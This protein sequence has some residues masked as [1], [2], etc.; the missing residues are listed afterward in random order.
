MI[1]NDTLR[2]CL[3]TATSLTFVGFAIWAL[4]RPKELASLLG[5][6]LKSS[7]AYSEFHAVYVGIFVGQSL[8]CALAAARV[9]DSM[10]GDLCAAFLLLQPVGRFSAM[11]RGHYPSGFLRLLFFAELIGGIALLAV[12]PA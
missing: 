5:F 12:R 9:S 11:A 3:L 8:V 6:E 2:F 10:L 4:V 7:N 1:I